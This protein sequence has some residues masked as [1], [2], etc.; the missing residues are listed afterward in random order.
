[1]LC[2]VRVLYVR[3]AIRLLNAQVVMALYSDSSTVTVAGSEHRGRDQI[4]AQ[5]RALGQ[6]E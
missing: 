5:I 4:C 3:D 1:M 2:T 6:H